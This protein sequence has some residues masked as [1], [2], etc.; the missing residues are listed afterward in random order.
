MVLQQIVT[1][2]FAFWKKYGYTLRQN[3]GSKGYPFDS[4]LCMKSVVCY[5]LCRR[6]CRNK[7]AAGEDKGNLKPQENKAVI[8]W[9]GAAYTRLFSSAGGAY[10]KGS[11]HTYP[12]PM[13]YNRIFHKPQYAKLSM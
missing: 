1:A 5:T 7:V 4:R 8:V 3:R 13:I 2:Y 6:C 11:S 12:I 10:M 9:R